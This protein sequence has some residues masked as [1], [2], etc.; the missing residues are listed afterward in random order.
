[1]NKI[2]RQFKSMPETLA[3]ITAMM[4]CLGPVV[5]ILAILPFSGWE[6]DNKPISYAEFW[7]SGGGIFV[8]LTGIAM[9]ILGIGFYLSQKWIRYAIPTGSFIFGAF[10]LL[11]PNIGSPMQTVGAF[12]WVLISWWYFFKKEAT[13]AYFTNNKIAEQPTSQGFGPKSGPLL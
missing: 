2:I 6:Y 4:L 9:T 5:I 8:T 1:M 12:I 11:V 3:V 10:S 7:S 13:V